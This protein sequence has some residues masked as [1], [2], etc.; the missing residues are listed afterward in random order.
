M[1]ASVFLMKAMSVGAVSEK[2]PAILELQH[3]IMTCLREAS[4]DRDHISF[5]IATL[6]ARVFPGSG[7]PEYGQAADAQHGVGV[8]LDMVDARAL[9]TETLA[10]GAV[11]PNDQ[12]G[13]NALP[14]NMGEIQLQPDLFANWGF[15]PVLTISDFDEFIQAIDAQQA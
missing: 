3:Q 15:D 10:A 9:A 12:M 7:R 4:V 13:G 2:E 6:L 14:V 11:V 5:E 1:F 8:A